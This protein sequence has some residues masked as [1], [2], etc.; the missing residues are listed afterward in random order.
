MTLSTMPLP[1]LRDVG[2]VWAT[3]TLLDTP[4][5]LEL[6]LELALVGHRACSNGL[7]RS[8]TDGYQ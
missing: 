6:A 1:F 8:D 7:L 5:L 2:F 3:S 4:L